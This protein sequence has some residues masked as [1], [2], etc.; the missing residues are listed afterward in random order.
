LVADSVVDAALPD[1]QPHS[2]APAKVLSK[3]LLNLLNFV[4]F[5]EGA[6]FVQFRD[7]N[8]GE[9]LSFQA[10]PL[11]VADETLQ[12]RWAS[13]DVPVARLAGCVLEEIL[14]S[15]GHTLVTLA[16]TV[17]RLDHDGLVL[18]LPEFGYEKSSR[19]VR[20]HQALGVDVEV[21]QHGLRFS[22][23]LT[24]FNAVSFQLRLQLPQGATFHGFH[25]HEPV[26]VTLAK[27]GV[28]LYSGEGRINRLVVQGT[29]GTLVV[30]PSVQNMRR[31]AP[32]SFRS[33]RQVLNPAPQVTFFHPLSGARVSLQAADLSGVGFGMEEFFENSLLLPG[34]ILPELTVEWGGQVLLRGAGQILYR[35][36][37]VQGA[38]KSVVRCGAVFLD[39]GLDDQ[40]RLAA[41][42]HQALDSHIRVC[43]PVDMDELWRFFFESGFLYPSKYAAIEAHKE[44]FKRVYE[45]LYLKSPS[46]SRHF[47]FE[48]KGTLFAHMSMVRAYPRSWLIHHHAAS[49]SGYGLAGVAV[50]DQMNHYINEFHLHRATQMDYVLCYYRKENK[51]PHR[52]FGGAYQDVADPKGIS[53]DTFAYLHLGAEEADTFVPFQILPSSEEDLTELGRVYERASGGLMLDAMGLRL[54]EESHRELADHFR[55]LGFKHRFE[56]FSLKQHGVLQAV[57]TFQVSD[58]GLNLSNL[59]NCIHVLV[60]DPEGLSPQALFSGLLNLTRHYAVEDLPVLVYPH[61]YLEDRKVPYEKNYLLW[62]LSMTH[63]DHCFHSFTNRFKRGTHGKS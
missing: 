17:V 39:L 32:K 30:L 19:Q 53:L 23:T 5:R 36:V 3:D 58:L 15:D 55:Q 6:L 29:V 49:R 25:I 61:T 38:S 26:T 34:L 60:T 4:N 27:G 43:G 57:V 52:V 56:V 33:V 59:T 41:V 9:S 48:D 35:N 12:C 45:K 54:P 62:V 31:F 37:Y 42:L 2:A 50:L 7:P 63:A 13:R 46:V 51:F 44:E 18:Q 47:L 28:L 40:A 20:R 14:V 24:D 10:F 21:F 1:S 16:A 22:G 8:R 11:P